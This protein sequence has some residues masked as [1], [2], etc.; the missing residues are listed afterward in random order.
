MY[1]SIIISTIIGFLGAN[2]LYLVNAKQ[3]ISLNNLIN[4]GITFYGGLVS[5]IIVFSI[6]NLI[7]KINLLYMLNISIPS[8]IITH[9]FGRIGC[10]FSGCCFGK[11]TNSFI[12]VVFPNN[13]IPYNF[14]GEYIRIVPTQLLESFYLFFLFFIILKYVKLIYRLASYFIFYGLFRFILEYFRGDNRGILFINILS[15]SQTISLIL[16][17]FGIM[18]S[19][20]IKKKNLHIKEELL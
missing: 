17:I 7:R 14:Y 12:G 15:P 5:G 2:V 6:Y 11:P 18:L 20:Y 4:S 3:N 16:I 8:V 10:F 9:A 13:S 1:I 19:I